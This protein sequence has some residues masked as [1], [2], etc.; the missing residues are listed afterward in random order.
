MINLDQI[1][2]VLAEQNSFQKQKTFWTVI[3]VYI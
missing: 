3:N 1:K 2:W